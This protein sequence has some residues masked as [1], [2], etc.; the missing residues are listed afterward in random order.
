MKPRDWF[1][2]LLLIA[3]ALLLPLPEPDL[4][5]EKQ[6]LMLVPTSAGPTPTQWVATK[7]PPP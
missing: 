6:A 3:V 4:G 2:L 7:K 1:L 5:P